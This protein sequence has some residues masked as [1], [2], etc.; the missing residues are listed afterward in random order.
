MSSWIPGCRCSTDP[1]RVDADNRRALPRAP[2]HDRRVVDVAGPH[3]PLG[4]G[5]GRRAGHRLAGGQ[6]GARAGDRTELV[7]VQHDGVQRHVAGVGHPVRVGDRLPRRAVGVRE[8]RLDEADGCLLLLRVDGGV[9]RAASDVIVVRCFPDRPGCVGHVPPA[10]VGLGDRVGGGAGGRLAGGDPGRR[11]G[12]RA[13]DVVV[14]HVHVVQGEVLRVG[15]RVDVGD[16]LAGVGVGPRPRGL[17]EVEARAGVDRDRG[18]GAPGRHGSGGRHRRGRG[19]AAGQR[20]AGHEGRGRAKPA[21][22]NGKHL[23]HPP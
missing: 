9:G 19:Q 11:A 6:R 10:H 2:D 22:P 3:I 23:S 13:V 20:R 4:R 8:R 15:H 1:H 18:V 12:D 14:G 7:V 5:V 17:R 21:A 16:P